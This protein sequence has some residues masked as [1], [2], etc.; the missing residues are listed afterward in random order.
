MNKLDDKMRGPS[1]SVTTA[2]YGTMLQLFLHED[3]S[4]AEQGLNL[5][6]LQCVW[7]PCSRCCS[8]C[9]TAP[10]DRRVP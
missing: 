1:F 9:C 2:G 7:P 5:A 10:P 4:A 6:T 8:R 3:P